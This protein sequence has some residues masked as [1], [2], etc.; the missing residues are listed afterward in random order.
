MDLEFDFIIFKYNSKLEIIFVSVWLLGNIIPFQPS[1][2]PQ[3]LSKFYRTVHLYVTRTT[4]GHLQSL[5]NSPEAYSSLRMDWRE[6]SGRE[7]ISIYSQESISQQ[8]T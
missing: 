4:Y 8:N 2:L 1:Y 6:I 7:L 5:L 3:D